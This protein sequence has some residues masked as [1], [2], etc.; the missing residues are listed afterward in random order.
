MAVANL[1]SRP[2]T[3][4]HDRRRLPSAGKL[5]ATGA[6]RCHTLALLSVL[7]V[8]KSIAHEFETPQMSVPQLFSIGHSTQSLES[9]I[10]LLN[11]HDVQ[12]VAD[13]R[14]A[15]FSRFNPQFNRRDLEFGLKEKGLQYV[16]LGKELGGRPDGDEFFDPDGHVLYGRMAESP[17]FKAGLNRLLDGARQYRVAMMCSEED[18]TDCHRFLLITRVLHTQNVPVVHIRGDATTQRTQDIGS[19]ADW[20]AGNL[21][22]ASLF[23]ESVRSP[24]RSTRSALPRKQPQSSSSR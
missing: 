20:S 19:F 23:D 9:L 15:P 3:I 12:V 21:E 4:N 1:A 10:R 18:P 5:D 16:F 17:E 8:R 7:A 13:V 14:T 2:W 22:Q 6:S 11:L 24:W